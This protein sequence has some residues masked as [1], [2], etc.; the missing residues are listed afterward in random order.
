MPVSESQPSPTVEEVLRFEDLPAGAIGQP[1]AIVRFSDGT[2]GGGASLV[3][4]RGA[5]VRGD[6]IGKTGEQLRS[7]HFRWD[8]EWL[9]S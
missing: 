4:R 1:S 2:D 7:L 8:R 3:C 9:Q 5:G 6:P